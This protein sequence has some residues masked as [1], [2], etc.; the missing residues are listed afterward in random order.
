[1][2]YEA[3]VQEIGQNVSLSGQISVVKPTLLSNKAETNS[4]C[5]N[6]FNFKEEWLSI[7][8][9]N[10]LASK[11]LNLFRALCRLGCN[12]FASLTTFSYFFQYTTRFELDQMQ[13]SGA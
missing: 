1:M 5:V 7:M 8:L 9:S 6:N 13:K 11:I 4:M 2:L 10:G 3:F 12:I